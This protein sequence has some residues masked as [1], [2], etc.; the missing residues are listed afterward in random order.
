MQEH[1]KSE[2]KVVLMSFQNPKKAEQMV[3]LV[4]DKPND[5]FVTRGLKEYFGVKEIRI[6]ASDVLTGLQQYAAVLAFLL[7]RMSKAEDLN[8]PFGYENVF[9]YEG[10]KYTLY[11]EGDYRVLRKME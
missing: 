10:R 4:W 1:E 6:E 9:E 5:D 7:E 8:L 11:E 2:E 3:E